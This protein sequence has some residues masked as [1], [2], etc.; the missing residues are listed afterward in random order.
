MNFKKIFSILLILIFYVTGV[1]ANDSSVRLRDR[2]SQLETGTVIFQDIHH[3]FYSE[4]YESYKKSGY[5]NASVDEFKID[6]S[7]NMSD[8]GTLKFDKLIST[9]NEKFINLSNEQWVEWEFVVPQSGLYNIKIDYYMKSTEGQRMPAIRKLLIDGEVPFFEA[10]TITFYRFFKDV[11]DV[12]YNNLGDEI[13]PSQEE[14]EDLQSMVVHDSLGFNPSPLQFYFE[15]GLSSIR[16]EYVDRGVYI[17]EISLISP[18]EYKSYEE[19]IEQYIKEYNTK[20]DFELDESIMLQATSII[21]KNDSSIR[22]ES[23]G[24]PACIPQSIGVRRLNVFGGYSWRRGGQAVS[25]EIEIDKEGFYQ[26]GVRF[27][28]PW[29]DGLPVYRQ[30][31]LNNEIPFEEFKLYKFPFDRRWQGDVISDEIGNP[32]LLYLTEGKH[33]LTMKVVLGPLADVVQGLFYDTFV[34]SDIIRDIVRITTNEPDP[35]FEYFLENRIPNLLARMEAL[36]LSIEDRFELLNSLSSRRPAAANRINL[37][38]KQL[39]E[40]ISRPHTIHRRLEDLRNAQSTL[41]SLYETLQISPLLLDYFLIDSSESNITIEK[42]NWVERFFAIIK[43]WLVSYTK[44]YDNISGKI[45]DDVD[46]DVLNVWVSQGQDWAEL[47]KELSDEQF[48]PLHEAYLNINLLPQTQL[49]IGAVNALMLAI[50]ANNQPD[51]VLGIAP[52]S[53]VELAIREA[54][55]NLAEFEDFDYVKER[56]IPGLFEPFKYTGGIYALPERMDFR[57]LIYR[58]DIF[59]ELS[60]LPPETWNDVYNSF[61]PALAHN[62]MNFFVPL[63]FGMF[64]FQNGGEFYRDGGMSSALD[65][66]E[67][68]NAFREWIELY[69]HYNI[70]IVANFYNRMRMGDIPAGIGNFTDYIMLT[71]AAPELTGRWAVAPVPGRL[72]ED[73][74]INRTVTGVVGNAGIILQ[75]TT[76]PNAAW[77]LLKWWTSSDVQIQFGQEIEALLGTE[78]R[79]NTAN[80]E[81]FRALPWKLNDLNVIE[82]SWPYIKEVPVVP[83]GYYTGRHVLNAWNRVV[84]SNEDIPRDSLDKAV[85]DIN[86][87]LTAKWE[88]Y[89]LLS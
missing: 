58:T 88:E 34:I 28:T 55:L 37:I 64:L 61:L 23:N 9:R 15:E 40:M 27:A 67:A 1:G 47:I 78:A 25:W 45:G 73:G 56:F 24:D 35:N 26:I 70:P 57:V 80:I 71:V 16:F 50:A 79:W 63:D 41:G 66:T 69:T 68:Y 43:T 21:H 12:R 44:D 75:R 65:S 39:D 76:N 8:N 4:V 17:S 29:S 51:V 19:Y 49:N 33:T 14:I 53:P 48:T 74:T 84:L 77:E 6:L 11:G 89:G 85:E 38:I 59:Q 52:N 62:N 46:Y 7:N 10:N 22:R 54:V 60:L 82:S 32:Y 31:L 20:N 3:S 81:A 72:N 83:G 30:I 5:K 13:R 2:Y 18:K 42:S 86:R 87:E 36:K